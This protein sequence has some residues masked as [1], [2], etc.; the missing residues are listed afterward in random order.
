MDVLQ[1]KASSASILKWTD[2]SCPLHGGQGS[3]HGPWSHPSCMVLVYSLASL[4][5]G[6][7]WPGA[8]TCKNVKRSQP[9]S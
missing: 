2:I 1:F 9:F 4:E 7:Q 5:Q 8:V 6:S 3:S